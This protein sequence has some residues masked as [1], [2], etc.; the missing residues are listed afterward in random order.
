MNLIVT[1]SRHFEEEAA[2]EI[3]AVLES[4]GDP[5][6]KTS[7]SR[8]SGIVL[9]DTILDPFEVIRMTR[10]R[11]I[12]E[13]WSIRYCHRF[14]PIQES[15]GAGLVGI[16]DIITRQ[17]GRMQPDDT[18][19]ITVE[20]R[21]SQLSTK[22]LIETIANMIKNR[23]SLEGYDWNIVVEVLGDIVGVSVLHEEDILS[24][25][26]VKRDMTE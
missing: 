12:N 21:G 25:L 20:K 14:I 11:I 16:A 13:P 1:C 6:A 7:H 17:I 10:E 3:S 9:V 18:Y 23:V 22:E 2:D 19:R 4:L 5:K 15:T 26:K 8:F 24:T